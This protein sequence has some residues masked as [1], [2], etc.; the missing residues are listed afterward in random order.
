MIIIH[1]YAAKQ[2]P[3]RLKLETIERNKHEKL[4]NNLRKIKQ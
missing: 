4:P 1:T 3:H 2:K